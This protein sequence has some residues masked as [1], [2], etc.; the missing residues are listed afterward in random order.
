[1]LCLRDVRAL[2]FR[3]LGAA[4]L[5]A[6]GLSLSA[7]EARAETN[8]A[9][10]VVV[11]ADENNRCTAASDLGRA[12]EQ[13]LGRRA[14]D[15]SAALTVRVTYERRAAGWLARIA[16]SDAQGRKLGE[17]ELVTSADRC[18]DLD[19]S[20]ALVAALLLDAPLP[21]GANE[22]S[23]STAPPPPPPPTPLMVDPEP[24]P[25]EPEERWRFMVGA[26]VLAV[27][28]R[29]SGNDLLPGARVGF[30]FKPP[31][32]MWLKLEAAFFLPR[33]VTHSE[34]GASAEVRQES[35]AVA[36]C[37]WAGDHSPAP[38]LC[39]GQELGFTQAHGQGLD[40]NRSQSRLGFT[41][42]GRA[43]LAFELFGPMWL[44]VGLTGGVPLVRDRYIISGSDQ[45]THELF[46]TRSIVAAGELGLAAALP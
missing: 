17:R 7:A 19:S 21:P 10:L 40:V 38:S 20:V 13:R 28:G 9:R 34:S 30:D 43:G 15:A 1:M 32:V 45:Q 18:D 24:K 29:L 23:P 44:R 36:A 41:I 33:T 6:G 37:P 25:T 27:W 16:L 14:F 22:P 12:V 35:V 42:F 39:F 3:R 46:R 5:T 11:G 8:T 31:H 4:A 26:D 2:F